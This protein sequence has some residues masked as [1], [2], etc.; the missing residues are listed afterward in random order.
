VAGGVLLAAAAAVKVVT[1]PVALIGL[2]AIAIISRRRALI[3][4]VAAA[5]AGLLYLAAVAIWLPHEIGWMLDIRLLQPE[6]RPLGTQLARVGEYLANVI[7]LWPLVAMIPAAMVG[8]P[9]RHQLAVATA[10]ALAFAPALIQNQFSPYQ[11]PA[12]PVVAAVAVTLAIGRSPRRTVPVVFLLVV[13]GWT[14][15]VLATPVPRLPERLPVWVVAAGVIGLAAWLW[16]RHV[17][18]VSAPDGR[19]APLIT[20]ALAAAVTFLATASPVAAQSVSLRGTEAFNPAQTAKATERKVKTAAKIQDTIGTQSTVTY[21]TFGDMAYFLRNP[22]NCR[23]PSPVFLQRSRSRHWQEGSR[24]WAETL[25][26]I[27]D[28]PGQWLVWDTA[29]FG[30]AGQPPEVKDVLVATFDCARA[31]KMGSFRICPRHHEAR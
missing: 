25:A 14:A 17:T 29:W 26:C 30:M 31:V 15:W 10:A 5:V 7:V 11:S 3:A 19:S 8:L 4:L 13:A 12:L 9:T 22:T 28:S 20:S 27:Q 16:Q 6:P 23:Y 1:L 18:R 2:L 21:L 24:S